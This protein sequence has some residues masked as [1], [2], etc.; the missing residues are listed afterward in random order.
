M[1]IVEGRWLFFEGGKVF[2]G[3]SIGWMVR[4]LFYGGG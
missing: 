2:N 1:T 4:W 3:Y